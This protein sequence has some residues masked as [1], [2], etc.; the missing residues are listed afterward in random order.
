LGV[1]GQSVG[2]V[3]A[4]IFL[5]ALGPALGVT[6][7]AVSLAVWSLLGSQIASEEEKTSG[8]TC[9]YEETR[10]YVATLNAVAR[11]AEP[12]W[13][14]SGRFGMSTPAATRPVQRQGA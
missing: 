4:A 5:Y 8:V 3:C 10:G 9:G 13:M 7:F 2:L 6:L 14:R 1:L 11:G 12:V